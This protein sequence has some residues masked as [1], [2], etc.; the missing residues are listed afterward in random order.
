VDQTGGEVITLAP[1]ANAGDLQS[2]EAKKSQNH[3]SLRN[4][5]S[6]EMIS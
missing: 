4:S 2:D 6:V 1:I 5:F 3:A